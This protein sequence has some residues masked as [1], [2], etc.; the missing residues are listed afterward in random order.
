MHTLNHTLEQSLIE[1]DGRYLSTTELYPLEQYIQSYTTRLETYQQLSKHS[2]KLT[3]QAL[4]KFSQAYPELIR[5]HG[6]RCKY[7]MSEVLRYIA[8]SI[9]R[10]D[11]LLFKEQMII[12]LDTILMAHKR[13]NHCLPAYQ[14]LQEVIDAT[15]PPECSSLV[16]PYLDIVTLSFKSH[17][18]K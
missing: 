14:H 5:Q 18:K 12:W 8:L 6:S 9:L 15:L 1:A 4:R 16:R 3:I 13:T 7:D 2:E 11:E 17:A 10:D